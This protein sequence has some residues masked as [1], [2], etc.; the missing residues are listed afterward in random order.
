MLC[1]CRDPDYAGTSECLEGCLGGITF[2]EEQYWVTVS[3]PA[4]YPQQADWITEGAW[5]PG[6]EEGYTLPTALKSIERKRPP[7]APAGIHRCDTDTLARWTSDS[8]RFPP[9]HYLPRFI[10]WTDDKWRLANSSEKESRVQGRNTKM[11]GCVYW[12]IAL[13][14]SPSSSQQRHCANTFCPHC[15][16][17]S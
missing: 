9:Y 15:S 13:A 1:L 16:T 14:S 2:S 7:P 8:Y 17:V 4:T 11:S 3:A 10:F 12:G 6:G 5:W